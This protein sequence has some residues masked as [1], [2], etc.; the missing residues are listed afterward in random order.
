MLGDIQEQ[1]AALRK[2]IAHIDQKYADARP[3]VAVAAPARWEYRP[4]RYQ[5]ENWCSG[6]EVSTAVG[7]HFESVRLYENHRRHG[8]M[9]IADLAELPPDLLGPNSEGAVAE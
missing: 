1:L 6:E 8:S 9:Y 7:T 2:R 5:I 3:M 4:A